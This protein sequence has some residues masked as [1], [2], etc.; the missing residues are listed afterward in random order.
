M[1][2]ADPKVEAI[3]VDSGSCR[4]AQRCGQVMNLGVRLGATSTIAQAVPRAH[5]IRLPGGDCTTEIFQ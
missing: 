1:G 3:S 4:C 5:E 2:S